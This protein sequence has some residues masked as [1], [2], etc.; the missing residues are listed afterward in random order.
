MY[1]QCIYERLYS[2]K[3]FLILARLAHQRSSPPQV[4]LSR[5]AARHHLLAHFHPAA[6]GIRLVCRGPSAHGGG[7]RRTAD[8]GP[9]GGARRPQVRHLGPV[10]HLLPRLLH[11]AD[12][13]VHGLRHQDP[14]RA[15]NLQRGQ[16][17]RIYDVHHLH[18][19]AGVHT[20][21]FWHVAVCREGECV[22]MFWCVS[23]LALQ[24]FVT[25]SL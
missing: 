6:G 8:P 12:G 13:D 20:H 4:H 14:G 3:T 19:L 24:L 17:H 11:P 2:P 21:I 16:T 22:R 7:L 9:H 5:L 1:F 10:P 18:H 15:R 25:S 23:P